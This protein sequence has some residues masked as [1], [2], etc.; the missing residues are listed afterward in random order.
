MKLFLC[1]GG[2]GKEII[3]AYRE[4]EN[5]IDK[6]KPILYIP[7]AMEEEKYDSCYEWF[8]EEI[9]NFG[10]TKF[11]MIRSSMEL[12]SKNFNEYSLIYIGGGNTYKLLKDLKEYSNF[13]KII[14]YLNN[15]GII[16]AGSAGASIFGNDINSCLL[17]D[18]NNVNLSDLSGFNCLDDYSI[19]CHLNELNFNKNKEYLKGYS[20]E[21]KMLYIPEEDVL[22]VSDNKIK[23][24][25]DKDCVI[26]D[27]G[28]YY[29]YSCSVFEK[30]F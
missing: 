12:S 21:F 16:F 26:F 7:L 8:S 14:D 15:D 18:D 10:C 11:D 2:S 6:L 13:D 28:E 23:M 20:K 5:Y 4:L 24:I 22:F 30:L 19:L 3:K 9:K 1:G 17:E 27:N 25:G 29:W